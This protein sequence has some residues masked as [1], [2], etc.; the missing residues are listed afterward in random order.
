[1]VNEVPS[2]VVDT[3][4]FVLPW[5]MRVLFVWSLERETKLLFQDNSLLLMSPKA[6]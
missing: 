1:M 4:G 2:S 6:Q 5:D 3:R